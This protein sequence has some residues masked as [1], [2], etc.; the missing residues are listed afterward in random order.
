[1]SGAVPLCLYISLPLRVPASLYPICGYTTLSAPLAGL[2]ASTTSMASITSMAPP[3]WHHLNGFHHLNGVCFAVGAGTD[4]SDDRSLTE[5]GR[6]AG[7][8]VPGHAYGIKD[9]QEVKKGNKTERILLLRNPWN[10]HNMTGDWSKGSGK[11]D[12]FGLGKDSSLWKKVRARLDL[13]VLDRSYSLLFLQ[14]IPKSKVKSQCSHNV[15]FSACPFFCVE[16]ILRRI[17]GLDLV[18]ADPC[19]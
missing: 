18:I 19:V 16:S 10:Q 1:M 13:N 15:L 7:G 4:G 2:F 6:N 3:Q 14:I 17:D 8:I 11:W 12:E 5:D 9:C